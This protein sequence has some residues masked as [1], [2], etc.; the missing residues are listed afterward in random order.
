MRNENARLFAKSFLVVG[1]AAV[2][3][4]VAIESDFTKGGGWAIVAILILLFAE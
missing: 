4:W 2:S 1:L 3:A